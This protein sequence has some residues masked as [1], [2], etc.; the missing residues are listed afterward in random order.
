VVLVQ[1]LRPVESLEQLEEPMVLVL[2][3]VDLVNLLLEVFRVEV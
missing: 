3:L 1:K 2:V